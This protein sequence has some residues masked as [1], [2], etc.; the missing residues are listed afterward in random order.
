MKKC[1]LLYL[2]VLIIGLP[3]CRGNRQI[4]TQQQT[5]TSTTP[6]GPQVQAIIEI[7]AHIIQV[8][9]I[10]QGACEELDLTIELS[11][12][13]QGR[14]SYTG[15]SQTGRA[16]TIEASSFQK[17]RTLLKIGIDGDEAGAKELLELIDKAIRKRLENTNP[18][19]EWTL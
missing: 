11:G 5:G 12:Q 9:E 10:I 16:I 2:C 6:A 18:L 1:S 15:K 8:P 17:G 4:N 14:Q 7:R 13:S 3:A 19:P